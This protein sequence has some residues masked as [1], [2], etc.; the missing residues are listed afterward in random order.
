MK[1][2]GLYVALFLLLAYCRGFSQQIFEHMTTAHGLSNNVV[3]SILQDSH[4]FY[5]I[6]TTDG[7]NRFD[8]SAVK[9]FRNGKDSRYSLAHNLVTDLLE[10]NE[11]NI[12]VATYNGVSIYKRREG[13][14]QNIYLKHPGFKPDILNRIRSEEHTSELQSLAYLVCRLLLE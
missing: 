9:I 1:K 3:N 4:G 11:G 13:R 8:G 10:D 2:P 6:G 5:W 12:W 14:F 7:L